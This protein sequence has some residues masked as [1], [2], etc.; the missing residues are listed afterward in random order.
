MPSSHQSRASSSSID[1]NQ[2]FED[3]R[4]KKMRRHYSVTSEMSYGEQN[5]HMY[6]PIVDTRGF[7]LR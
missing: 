6:K 4:S 3:E 1:K 7:L 5:V 2:R